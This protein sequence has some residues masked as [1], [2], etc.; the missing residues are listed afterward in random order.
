METKYRQQLVHTEDSDPHVMMVQSFRTGSDP[1]STAGAVKPRQEL[2]FHP[3]L[4]D[5]SAHGITPAPALF[6]TNGSREYSQPR[7]LSKAVA[8]RPQLWEV[9]QRNEGISLPVSVFIESR[10]QSRVAP[11]A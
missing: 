5:I 8:R 7:N 4:V 3:S 11:G 1:K 10:C 2:C 9:C 6:C